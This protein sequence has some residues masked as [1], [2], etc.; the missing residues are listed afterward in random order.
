M[1]IPGLK[2]QHDVRA[3]VRIGEKV[4]KQTSKGERTFP[5]SVDY[6]I[7]DDSEFPVG[8]PKELRVLLPFSF[9]GDNFSTGL[10][11]WAGKMLVCYSKGETVDG[12]NVAWRKKSMKKGGR[13][14]NLLEGFDVIG[15]E[16]GNE[17]VGVGCA[18]R[19]CP[20]MLSKECRPMGR[21][22]FWIEGIDPRLGIFQLDTKSWN[23]IEKIEATL[24]TCGDP[25]GQ[26]FLLRV[27]MQT[28]G[29]K[30]F[31]VVSLT[32]EAPVEI[33]NENDV[34]LAEA[35]VQLR[36]YLDVQ[37]RGELDALPEVRHSLAAVLDLT[38]PGWRER[39]D[40][41]DRI[42]EVGVVEAAEKMLEAVEL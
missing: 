4:T 8:K 27:E 29:S 10:E 26:V 32:P 1:P 41:V 9:P 19:D 22:Q 7:C 20:M 15:R 36:R 35:Y 39:Q 37:L 14:V 17:R 6:F 2:P 30:H 5:T 21:L 28:Q 34:E 13:D 38:N 11:Q 31:P 40:F 12:R 24:A 18:V 25:R 33:N 42:K 23:S 3:K 16:M